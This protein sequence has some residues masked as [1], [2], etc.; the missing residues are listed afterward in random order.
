MGQFAAGIVATLRALGTNRAGIN[1]L[2]E[3]AVLMATFCIS[4]FRFPIMARR[5]A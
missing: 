4:T 5:R 2:A 3:V 1:A